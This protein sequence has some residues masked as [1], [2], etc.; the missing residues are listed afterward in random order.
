MPNAL[1]QFFGITRQDTGP[2]LSAAPAMVQ[3]G[4][5]LQRRS[6][7]H[8]EADPGRRHPPLAGD[9]MPKLISQG[10]TFASAFEDYPYLWSTF[11]VSM[12]T[13]AEKAGGWM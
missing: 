4:A 11:V 2:L 3:A 9:C 1:D 13:A 7:H 6:L 10:K 8:P 12:V 5:D